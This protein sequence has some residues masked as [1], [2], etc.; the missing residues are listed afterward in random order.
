MTKMH[1][2]TN[3]FSAGDLY[4]T[5]DLG[6]YNEDGEIEFVNRID[7]QIKLHGLRI[8]LGEIES[9]IIGFDGIINSVVTK[10][11]NEKSEYLCG[12]FTANDEV[13]IPKLRLF[14]SGVLPKYMVPS[15]LIQIDELPMTQNGKIDKTK[16]P[17]PLDLN[18]EKEII[19]ARNDTDKL[20]LSILEDLLSIKH[21]SIEDSF[22]EIG[23]DSLSAIN[24][25]LEIHSKFNKNIS[26]KDIFN[27]PII[28]DLSDLIKAKPQIIS[29]DT[30]IQKIEESDFYDASSAQKRIYISSQIAGSSL[31]YNISGGII[32]DGYLDTKKLS[33]AIQELIER[34]ESLRTYFENKDNNLIQKIKK[35]IDFKLDVSKGEKYDN[36]NELYK[37]FV[38]PFD[39]SKAPLFNCKYIEFTNKKSVIFLNIHHIISDGE[40]MKIFAEEL[41]KLYNG[42]KL[43]KTEFT[44]KDYSNFENNKS[45]EDDK[46]YWL[47]KF[48]DTIPLLN[49]PTTYSRPT[50]KFYDGN[51]VYSNIDSKTAKE[52]KDYC[53]RNNITPFTFLLACYYIILSRYSSQDDIVIGVP[54]AN[55]DNIKTRD[56]FGMFVNT[57]AIREKIN[58]NIEFSDFAESLQKEMI[59]NYKHSSYPFDDLVNNLRISRDS[60]RSPLFDVMFIYQ[61]NGLTSYNFEGLKTEYYIPDLSI[62]KFD[63]SLEV[64]PKD[65]CFDLSF[66]YSNKLFSAEY[67]NKFASHFINI[68][69]TIVSNSDI[70]LNKISMI[71]NDE[72]QTIL[73]VFNNTKIYYEQKTIL[74]LFEENSKNN[75]DSTAITF[76]GKRISYKTLNE[77]ANCLANYLIQKNISSD[78][79]IAILLDR[80]F[81]LI[82]SIWATIKSGAQFVIIDTEY[83]IDRI[84]YILENS[85]SKYIITKSNTKPINIENII[86]ISKFNYEVYN[87]ENPVVDYNSSLCIIYTSGSTGNPKGVLLHKEGY[88]NLLQAFETDMNISQYK[89]MLSI[90]SS[91]FDMFAFEVLCATTFGNNLI[92]ADSEEQKNPIAMSKLIKNENVDFMVTTPSRVEFLL[93]EECKNPLEIVKAILF[94]GESFTENLYNRLEKVTK[95]KI[96]N[97]YGPTE[98]TS[99]CTNK[100]ITSSDITVGKPLPNTE[101]YIC[102]SNLN[103]LPIGI[104]GEICVGGKGVANGYLNNEEITRKHFLPNPFNSGTLYRT[105][106][107]G[108]YREDGEIEF[109]NRMD[110]Q[111]KLRGLRIELGE[112]ESLLLKYPNIKKSAVVKQELNNREFLSAYYVADKKIKIPELR[113]YLSRF[114]PKYMV[115][116]Y[117]TA[118]FELPYTANGKVDRKQLPIPKNAN[119]MAKEDY[120]LPK[121]KLEKQLVAIWENTLGIKPI[122]IHDNFFELGGDSLLAMNLNMEILKITDKITYAD[123]F[124]FPTIFE[125]EKKISSEENKLIFKKME[126]LPEEN[127]AIL[128]KTMKSEKPIEYHPKNILLTG[129]TGFLG[130]HIL[131]EF[132]KNETGRIYCIVRDEPGIKADQKLQQKL[133]YYFGSDYNNLIGDRIIL[134][135]GNIQDSDFG[136]S[137]KAAKEL[138]NNIDVVIHSA[139]IVTH[140]GNYNDF[141]NSNVQSTK[142]I[143]NF[144]QKYNKKLYHISTTGVAG[145]ELDMSFLVTKKNKPKKIK[146]DESSLYIGQVLDNVYMRS[147]F[148]AENYVLSA[149]SRGLDAYILRMGNLM[150]RYSDGMFQENILDNAFLMKMATFTE[151]GIMPKYMEKH[152]LNFTPVDFASKA[153]YKLV[154]HPSQDNRVFHLYNNK[155]ITVKKYLRSLKNS[156]LQIDILD[157]EEFTER[158]N[159]ILKNDEVKGSLNNIIDDLDKQLHLN[160]VSDIITMSKFTVKYLRKLHFSW[161]IIN[162]QYLDKFNN[163]LRRAN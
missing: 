75:P 34:H 45:F 46:K 126:N 100:L 47:Q 9:K 27:N 95:A 79:T 91:T 83:P 148:E 90:A 51:K 36:L 155:N 44:Y 38:K 5:G 85:N 112:I 28:R 16:L 121:T 153:I 48:E 31:L 146:F 132:I 119:N 124:Q 160:Y 87:S 10:I 61:N 129:A 94:G 74:D 111:I 92:L 26:I 142:Y 122:G 101:V 163:I 4:K 25:T 133:S 35:K 117:Y 141:F 19:E 59:E 56:I 77:K 20:L 114:L 53:K 11:T 99:A 105:G 116:S 3:P 157:E 13:N 23:G 6:K 84:N 156:D 130:I 71:T 39:L 107:L 120:E 88:Y 145:V 41:C 57:L 108:K 29:E 159:S 81:E 144:C 139:A 152:I 98:I 33:N 58:N 123:I 52:I 43:N 21:I 104:V 1:L 67:I 82:T 64:I 22:F 14:L 154:T 89:N 136:L 151:L 63:L 8:E 17:H 140:F 115:P 76:K 40:S 118:M 128:D 135:T 138:A 106:D 147:K 32:V 125:L 66:E 110:N 162:T 18:I 161:P 60:S 15:Y 68:I 143:I 158:I 86:D 149:I 12:Y 30:G 103:L 150:P 62:S 93:K 113:K 7:N 69:N 50:T 137:P 127:I 131:N 96:Y 42:E 78:D 24:L 97:S 49:L 73:N 80:S 2:F 72:L 65:R 54:V 109:V 55:R 37:K 134:V 70:K 102:D